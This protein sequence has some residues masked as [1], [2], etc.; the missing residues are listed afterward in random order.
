MKRRPIPLLELRAATLG[1][2][3]SPILREVNLAV[4]EGDFLL[5]AGANGSGK[6]TL[7]RSLL[8]AL[9]MQSGRR[10]AVADLRVGYVPQQMLLDPGFPASVQDVVAMGLWGKHGLAWEK[11]IQRQQEVLAQVE[12]ESRKRALFGRLSGGQKQRVLLARALV[13]KPQ[14]LLLD[15]PVSGVD[16]RATEIILKILEQQAAKGTAVILVSHQP[17]ALREC[18]TRAVLVKHGRLEE[19][20]VIEMCSAEGLKKLWA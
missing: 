15:E 8:G 17:L 18:A 10:M 12:M 2:P 14:L 19:L 1:Y 11:D 16:A 6:S 3:H 7:V 4:A 20:P 13:Q 5:L 9:P